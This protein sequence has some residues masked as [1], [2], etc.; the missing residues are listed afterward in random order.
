MR[1]TTGGP[2]GHIRH[3]ENVERV[4]QLNTDKGQ[5]PKWAGEVN[6]MTSSF[7]LGSGKEMAVEMP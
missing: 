5:P 7:G 3:I 4:N 2:Y 1:S 6:G